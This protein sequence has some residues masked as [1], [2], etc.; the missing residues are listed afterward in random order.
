MQLIKDED[1]I[2]WVKAPNHESEGSRDASRAKQHGDFDDDSHTVKAGLARILGKST[3]R[4]DFSF[5][6][7]PEFN[8]DIRR[9]L[10]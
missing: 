6:H 5:A 7:S 10:D 4:A 3:V 1:R 8:R 9:G 2:D